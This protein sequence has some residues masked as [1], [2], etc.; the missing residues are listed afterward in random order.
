MLIERPPNLKSIEGDPVRVERREHDQ[1]LHHMPVALRL[2]AH[3]RGS[4][5][6][7]WIEANTSDHDPDHLKPFTGVMVAVGLSVPIWLT[8]SG[9]LYYLI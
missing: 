7:P 5:E 2:P 4:A 1:R 8:I 9:L 3:D 6:H